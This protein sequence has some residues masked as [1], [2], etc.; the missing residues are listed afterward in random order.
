MNASNGMGRI[1]SYPTGGSNRV[2]LRGNY[3]NNGDYAGVFTMSLS[4]DAAISTRN[5][6]FRCA[7]R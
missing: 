3:G 5:V 4:W 1:Y 7:L 2:L 6:G